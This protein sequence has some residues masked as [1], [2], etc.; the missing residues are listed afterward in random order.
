MDMNL[1]ID[2]G[3]S[4]AKMTL[5]A[6]D[7]PVDT[8]AVS[9]IS[10]GNVSLFTGRSKVSAAII[11][12]V[13]RTP[14][15][16]R[17][18]PPALAPVTM[19]MTGD[20]PVPLHNA[21]AT[22]S[23]LGADRL[24][25]AVGAATLF[26]GRDLLVVDMGTAVTY[27]HVTSGGTFAGGFIA[28][29]LQMRLDALHDHTARLPRLEAAPIDLDIRFATSTREAMLGGAL[30]GICAEIRHYA[31]ISGPDTIVCLTGRNADL[32]A[33]LLT[34]LSPAVDPLLVGRGLNRIIQHNEQ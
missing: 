10:A 11:C 34:D 29:G 19:V 27:D 21:Y 20:T 13:G 15:V 6:G 23:T 28:P 14:D 8:V 12:S 9:E 4:A 7:K 32:A 33:P 2:R 18:M 3:N 26:P 22:P 31:R 5:W 30:L 16:N 17:D 25:A 24:A 1:T